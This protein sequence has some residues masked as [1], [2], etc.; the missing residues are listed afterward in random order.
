VAS[1]THNPNVCN[2][3]GLLVV[4]MLLKVLIQL[5]RSIMLN[6]SVDYT[7]H[8]P[9]SVTSESISFASTLLG[10]FVLKFSAQVGLCPGVTPSAVN[11]RLLPSFN[12]TALYHRYLQV[13]LQFMV[14]HVFCI[15]SQ[16]EGCST[17]NIS[18]T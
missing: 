7:T 3:C 2:C 10:R 11:R 12:V 16:I 1:K 13:V 14:T 18:S 15:Y 8:L 5:K 6:E 9:S 17:Q 4:S